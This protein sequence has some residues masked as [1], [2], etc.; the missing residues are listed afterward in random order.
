MKGYLSIRET[1]YKWGVFERRINQHVTDGR[2]PGV[3]RFGRSWAI[4]SDA[5]KPVDPRRLPKT[6]TRGLQEETEGPHL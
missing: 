3:E 4:P 1:S 6:E 2:I 5:D